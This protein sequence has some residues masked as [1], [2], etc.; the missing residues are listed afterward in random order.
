MFCVQWHWTSP[1]MTKVHPYF[2]LGSSG[3]PRIP[4]RLVTTPTLR[5]WFWGLARLLCRR[6]ELKL[7]SEYGTLTRERSHGPLD[8]SQTDGLPSLWENAG[9]IYRLPHEVKVIPAI[10]KDYGHA[11]NVVEKLAFI[12]FFFFK[13]RIFFLHNTDT[14]NICPLAGQWTSRRVTLKKCAF[15][16]QKIAKKGKRKLQLHWQPYYILIKNKDHICV[17][18]KKSANVKKLK[19]VCALTHDNERVWEKRQRD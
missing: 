5:S 3:N 8:D 19:L 9:T 15:I 12:S 13:L 18:K 10:D 1:E 4:F 7:R 11:W 16:S 6:P 2:A 17:Y 14:N